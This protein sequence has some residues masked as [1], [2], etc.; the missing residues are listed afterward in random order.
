MTL[1]LIVAVAENGVIGLNN[2]MPWHLSDDLKYFKQMTVGK[3]VVM[4]R[5]TY[6]SLGRPLPQR[7]NVVITRNQNWSAAPE[8]HNAVSI[9]HSLPHALELC[10][11]HDPEQEVMIIGG[12][13]IF[14]MALPLADRLYLTEVHMSPAGDT[15]FPPFDRK[16][17]REVSR[18]PGA[19]SEKGENTHD[20][21]LLE[22]VT[23]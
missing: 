16:D 21:V 19:S 8:H 11:Q 3:A 1:S 20:F 15:Y 9:A 7:H 23:P 17:W 5:K 22:R 13:D 6:D 18:R 10:R 2:A 4:G 12:A 14:S